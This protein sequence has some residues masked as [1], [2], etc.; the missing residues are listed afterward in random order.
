M[1]N[2]SA[3][4]ANSQGAGVL[5]Q[6][7]VGEGERPGREPHLA[8]HHQ[9][10][11]QHEQRADKGVDEELDRR[12]Q[13]ALPAPDPDDE[14]HRDQHDLPEDI[15]HEHVQRYEDT[16]HAGEHGQQ[17]RVVPPLPLLDV[18]VG[19]EHAERHEAGGEQHHEERDA[20]DPHPIGDAPGRQPV[21]RGGELHGP[22]PRHI[23]PPEPGGEHELRHGDPQG[24]VLRQAGR[25]QQDRHDPHQRQQEERGNDPAGIADRSQE[26]DHR[27]LEDT[28]CRM[29]GNRQSLRGRTA[30]EAIPVVPCG[31]L[32]ISFAPLRTAARARNDLTLACTL[33]LALCTFFTLRLRTGSTAPPP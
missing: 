4:A 31:I 33:H 3:K 11:H 6:V 29:Q 27:P 7:V 17:E 12:I 2:A 13:P 9:D 14:I 5:Q 28:A 18:L 22:L 26:C 19:R 25:R 10:G 32:A 1:A 8:H 30:P 20:V 24:E 23:G 21:H 15:E 16:Q